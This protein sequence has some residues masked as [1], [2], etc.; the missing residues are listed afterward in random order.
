MKSTLPSPSKQSEALDDLVKTLVVSL[1]RDIESGHYA[2]MKEDEIVRHVPG[3]YAGLYMERGYIDT[4]KK[5]YAELHTAHQS[6][7]DEE[8]R[9]ERRSSREH[10]R[11]W[12][13]RGLTAI[14]VAAVALA[15]AFIAKWLGIALP[16]KSL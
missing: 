5:T 2:G 14:T 3:R 8:Q 11:T 4:L 16:I 7:S 10:R 12:L 15:A 9:L 1:A 13:Y 6:L